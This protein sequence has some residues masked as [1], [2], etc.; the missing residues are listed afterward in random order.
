MIKEIV[1]DTDFLSQPAEATTAEDAP[2]AGD[3]VDTMKSVPGGC[4]CLAANQIGSNKAI[5]AYQDN[6]RIF[7]MYNPK[8]SSGMQRFVTSESCLSLDEPSIA[9]R[10]K[11]VTVSY[12]VLADGKLAPRKRK[13]TG[14]TAQAVQHAIDHCE[15]KLV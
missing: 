13:F 8:V 12:E 15:G 5:I 6:D 1:K 7:V 14:W 11:M 10:F 2:V 3:L 4:A 9:E